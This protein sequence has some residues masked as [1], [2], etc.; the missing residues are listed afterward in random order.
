VNN[1]RMKAR[2]PRI[3][4]PLLLL[5]ALSRPAAGADA[6]AAS[7]RQA[8]EDEQARFASAEVR[9]DVDGMSEMYLDRFSGR[10]SAVRRLERFG[11]AGATLVDEKFETSNIE[12]CDDIAV[13]SGQTVAEW[14]FPGRPRTVDRMRYLSVWKRAPEGGWKVS[15][16]LWMESGSPAVPAAATLGASPGSVAA[17]PPPADVVPIPDARSLGSG[18]IRSIQDDLKGSANRLRSLADPVKLRGAATKA[19]RDLQKVIRDVG[20]IDVGRF[21]TVAACNAAYIVSQ[22]G[23]AALMRATLPLMEQDLNDASYDR[24]CYES[25]LEAYRSLAR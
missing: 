12:V 19:D 16:D 1:R 15:R 13:A 8:I 20:W 25:A 23:D 22:S 21:G 18:F 14:D 3:A 5:A 2:S 4:V 9:R 10:E 17:V 7:V 6:G 11:K 24:S